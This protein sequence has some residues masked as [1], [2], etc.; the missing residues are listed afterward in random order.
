MNKKDVL[1]PPPENPE[2]DSQ[3]D[4]WETQVQK[5]WAQNSWKYGKIT[6]SDKPQEVDNI[7][8]EYTKPV[9]MV[10]E[11][12]IDKIYGI[13]D[14]IQLQIKSMGVYPLQKIDVFIN[15]AYL[16]IIHQVYTT[17]VRKANTLC[18]EFIQSVL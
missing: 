12:S 17:Y 9:I 5:W 13:N 4:H 10:L 3:F 15:D 7:H 2:K 6:L 8:T 16:L 18:Q 14:K 1:G 11:P